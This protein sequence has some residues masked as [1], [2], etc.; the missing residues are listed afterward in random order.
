MTED[1]AKIKWCPFVRV[2]ITPDNAMWK[3]KLI[4]N[5]SEHPPVV[6]DRCIGSDCALWVWSECK[7]VTQGR[8][9]HCGMI[10]K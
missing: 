1:E 6:N 9:G 10:Q 2:L 8:Q 4:S 3:G 5:R 7:Q